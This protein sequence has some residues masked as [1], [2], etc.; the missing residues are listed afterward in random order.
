MKKFFGGFLLAAVVILLVIGAVTGGDEPSSGAPENTAPASQPIAEP[1]G[2]PEDSSGKVRVGST[3][4]AG[5]F[6]ITYGEFDSDWREYPW[7]AAPDD[8][9]K[10][11]RAYFTLKNTD[12]CDHRCSVSNFSCYADGV[13]CKAWYAVFPDD[14]FDVVGDVSPG[15]AA[16]GYVYFEVPV[17][18]D[19][20]ELE[21]EVSS[22]TGEKIVFLGA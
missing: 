4:E 18:A 9:N 19:L 7:S 2:E 10:H 16:Q 17:D 21:Y 22:R 5:G 11:I 14:L 3:V 13:A 8:G 6:S 1:A 12:T 20:I 15:R